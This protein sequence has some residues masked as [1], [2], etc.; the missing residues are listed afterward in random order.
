MTGAGSSL[1]REKA[2]PGIWYLAI[3]RAMFRRC[4]TLLQDDDVNSHT[5]PREISLALILTSILKSERCVYSRVAARVL[6]QAFS[7]T[8]TRV[9]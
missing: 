8:H 9:P 4:E 6:Y 5:P 1:H 2:I 7:Y 3:G